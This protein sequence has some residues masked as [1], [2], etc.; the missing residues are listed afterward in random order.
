M[1]NLSVEK[2][3]LEEKPVVGRL[4]QLCLR[5]LAAPESAST[6]A[7][8]L[9]P[10]PWFDLYWT[11]VH[12]FPHLLRCDGRLAGFAFVREAEEAGDWQWQIAEFFVLPAFRKIKVGT[13]AACTLLESRRGIW[14]VSWARTNGPARLF[15]TAVAR[16]FDP[17]LR[18]SFVESSRAR[19][20]IRTIQKTEIKPCR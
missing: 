20:L 8:E 18:A 2:A 17:A 4:L 15:W 7:G 12:R 13:A 1:M 11:S 14:E 19:F 9:I 6:G 5:E 3:S 16:H 10:Y